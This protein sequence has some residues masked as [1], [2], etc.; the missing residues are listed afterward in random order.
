MDTSS[1][2][3]GGISKMKYGDDF[4]EGNVV[5]VM[6]EKRQAA[7]DDIYEMRNGPK[8]TDNQLYLIK[9]IEDVLD[10]KFMG[11]TFSDAEEFINNHIDDYNECLIYDED[12]TVF[13]IGE[14]EAQNKY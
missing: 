4:D 13:E 12:E 3:E 7:L 9:K 2:S 10:I 11:D 5:E 6:M 8:A 14:F 1:M